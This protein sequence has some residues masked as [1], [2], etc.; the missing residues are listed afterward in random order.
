[1]KGLLIKLSLVNM[2]FCYL[3]NPPLA[4]TQLRS[5]VLDDRDVVSKFN[6]KFCH[7]EYDF[8]QRLG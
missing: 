5:N 7:P 6:I 1:M 2:P 3:E 4:L 8:V